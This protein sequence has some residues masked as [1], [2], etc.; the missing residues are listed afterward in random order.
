[1]HWSMKIAELSRV[2]YGEASDPNSNQVITR[3][4]LKK[5]RINKGKKKRVE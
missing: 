3:T 4:L 5:T 1:M 2:G